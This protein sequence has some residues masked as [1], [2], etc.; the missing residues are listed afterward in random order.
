MLRM[1][2]VKRRGEVFT[3]DGIANYMASFIDNSQAHDIL[4]PSCGDGAILRHVDPM[5]R[6]TA[7]D[8]H[9]KHI[10][11]CQSAF[12]FNHWTFVH[13][14]FTTFQPAQRFDYIIGNP[15]YVKIQNMKPATIARMQREYPEFIYGNTNLFV[16]FIA[17][18]LDLLKDDGKLIFIVPNTILYNKSL[19]SMKDHLLKH[20]MIERIIDFKDTQVFENA[21]TYTCILVLTRRRNSS[22]TLQYGMEGKPK[23]IRYSKVDAKTKAND[24][25]R[26][27][28]PRIGVMTLADDVFIIKDSTQKGDMLHFV[29]DGKAFAIE[30]DAC[31][32]ILK[33]SK[34]AIHKAI[35]PYV[36]RDGRVEINHQFATQFPLCYKYLVAYKARLDARDSGKVHGYPAWYA[37]GRT[38]A[39]MPMPSR[40]RMFLPTV[41]RNIHSSITIASVPLHYAGLYLEPSK[42]ATLVEMRKHLLQNESKIL[43]QSNHRA[44]GW[45]A[46]TH[47]SFA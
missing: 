11:A 45:F 12:P 42:G 43:Q 10:A 30:R 33:V 36:V 16:Y 28:T 47:G 13:H 27:F 6:V 18:C 17:R 40:R 26:L 2:A 8:I 46:L 1:H 32:D 14:D 5:H 4:E 15:P 38:Q 23:L 3:P 39:L 35:Y 41:V 21:T 34:D 37:Y 44:G 9:K 19:R 24:H 20:G 7:V 29:K 25:D 31:L 22:Y